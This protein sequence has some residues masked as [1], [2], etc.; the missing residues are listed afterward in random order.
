MRITVF[1]VSG[2]HFEP[3]GS[4]AGHQ[5]ADHAWNAVFF[6]G[7]WRLL[8]CT[9]GAGRYN[10]AE[11]AGATDSRSGSSSVG[12]GGTFEKELNEHYFLTDPDEM[13]YTH[14]PYDEVEPNYSR[15]VSSLCFES[16]FEFSR[17]FS[18]QMATV[19]QAG[20]PGCV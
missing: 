13:I 7:G 8:D 3:G 5:P 2:T 15:L 20:H 14:F 18:F 10:P 4:H 12:T 9:W 11:N 16:I 6:Y 1:L 17:H 19:D